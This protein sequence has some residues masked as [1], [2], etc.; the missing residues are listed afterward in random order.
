[1]LHLLKY[2][3]DMDQDVRYKGK[4][5]GDEIT[6]EWIHVVRPRCPWISKLTDLNAEEAIDELQG[7][8]KSGQLAKI[9]ECDN[10]A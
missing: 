3:D 4:R 1:M 5:S 7:Q 8:C 9:N 2:R 6:G 10:G